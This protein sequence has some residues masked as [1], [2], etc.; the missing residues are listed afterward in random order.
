MRSAR[1]RSMTERVRSV[2]DTAYQI[3]CARPGPV[4]RR[5]APVILREITFARRMERARAPR[6][7]QSV[8]TGETVAAKLISY[9][10]HYCLTI[11]QVD[12]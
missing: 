6:C 10:I 3:R 2:Q 7:R 1:S 11:R 5:C 9:A 12:D 4:L 8:R